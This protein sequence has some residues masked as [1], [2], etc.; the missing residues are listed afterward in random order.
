MTTDMII[1]GQQWILKIGVGRIA[2]KNDRKELL[3]W[4][5]IHEDDATLLQRRSC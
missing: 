4:Q 5:K 1:S 3:I 2:I